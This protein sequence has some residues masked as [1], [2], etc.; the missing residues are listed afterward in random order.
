M[1]GE[2]ELQSFEVSIP[3]DVANHTQST[4]NSKVAKLEAGVD[5][6]WSYQSSDN[7]DKA[8]IRLAVLSRHIYATPLKPAQ[9]LEEIENLRSLVNI[10]KL[11]ASEGLVEEKILQALIKNDSRIEIPDKVYER[12]QKNEKDPKILIDNYKEASVNTDENSVEQYFNINKDTELSPEAKLEEIVTN[13]KKIT[14][15]NLSKL[16][17]NLLELSY[18][19]SSN[20]DAKPKWLRNPFGNIVSKGAPDSGNKA[21]RIVYKPFS[22]ADLKREN[23]AIN[24]RGEDEKGEVTVQLEEEKLSPL[25]TNQSSLKILAELSP[26]ENISYEENIINNLIKPAEAKLEKV[27]ETTDT[28]NVSEFNELVNEVIEYF[29]YKKNAETIFADLDSNAQTQIGSPSIKY[30]NK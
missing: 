3:H 30:T 6:T 8:E 13:F 28:V 12:N 5:N 7:I 24:F 29:D 15:L 4:H 17:N 23:N 14:G 19:D 16:G 11:S 9:G 1:G 22:L 21:K 26:P 2:E 25:N 10:A 27:F 20:P 18:V